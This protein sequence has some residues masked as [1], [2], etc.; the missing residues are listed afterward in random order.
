MTG[1]LATTGSVTN[2]SNK[3]EKH[4]EKKIKDEE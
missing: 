2:R 1:A 4:K 3:T